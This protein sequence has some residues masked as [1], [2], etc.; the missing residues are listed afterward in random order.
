M[1]DF[2]CE[3]NP[4]FRRAF[5]NA[6][7]RRKPFQL[8][9]EAVAL[10]ATQDVTEQRKLEK[11][12]RHSQKLEAV[13]QF[14]AGVAHD[15][16]NILT[17]IQGHAGMQLATVNLDKS[18]AESLE[19]VSAAAER[20]AAL[21]RQLLTF[22]RKQVVQPRMLDLNERRP[23]LARDARPHHR[24]AHRSAM[25]LSRDL[26]AIFADQSNIEQ[27]VM[28]LVVNARDAMP[29]GGRLAIA[30]EV[31]EVD[32]AHVS[33]NP[34]ARP[35]S[36]VCLCVADTGCG[37]SPETLSHIFE[38]FFTTKEVGKGTGLGPGH[39]LWHRLAAGRL[40]RGV[41]SVGRGLHLQIFLSLQ[42]RK[43]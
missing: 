35:G 6:S 42:R 26:P 40:D 39:G 36:F 32:A 23:E 31:V 16:N 38:P 29:Q 33:R 9:A 5:G 20:A 22:S 12:L 8:G 4:R 1:R 34:Q 24:R 21:T 13:G 37:M 28:N 10:I 41:A 3:L 19:Q 15:F 18:I 2:E 7:S 11:Q 25:R 27:I 43:T 14:A 30:T 17:V